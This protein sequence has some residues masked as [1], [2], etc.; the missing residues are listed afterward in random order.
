LQARNTALASSHIVVQRGQPA[1]TVNIT[2]GGT[3]ASGSQA[4]IVTAIVGDVRPSMSGEPQN[5]RC[6]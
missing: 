3:R 6:A 1:G 2:S 5:G 4:R